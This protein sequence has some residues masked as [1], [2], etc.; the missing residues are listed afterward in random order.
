FDWWRA[1][2]ALTF[3]RPWLLLLLLAIPLLAYL[4]GKHGPAAALTFSSTS[5]FRAI[6][7]QSAARAG[8]ILRTL[9][10]GSLAIFVIALARPQ[11]GK[12]LTQIAAS[13][14]DIMLVPDVSGSMLTKDF[15][16]GGQATTRADASREV[17]RTIIEGRPNDRIGIIAFAGRPGQHAL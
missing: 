5:A 14:I 2:S 7:K 10:L 6:G 4:R 8:K 17:T 11:L 15:T 13:G 16:S 12:S 3:A 1:N 9:L